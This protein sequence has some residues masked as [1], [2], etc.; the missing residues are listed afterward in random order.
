MTDI[1]FDAITVAATKK[2]EEEETVQTVDKKEFKPDLKIW[3]PFSIVALA[4]I[5]VV[6][7][8]YLL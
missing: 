1:D 7:W 6:V 8:T 2:V 3:I 4:F 5:G